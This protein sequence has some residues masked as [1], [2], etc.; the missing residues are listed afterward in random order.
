MQ[1]MKMA[2]INLSRHEN[3]ALTL[4]QLAGLSSPRRDSHLEKLMGLQST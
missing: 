3:E 4:D 1:N 2:L